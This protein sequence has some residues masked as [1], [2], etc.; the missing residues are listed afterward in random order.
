MRIG[1]LGLGRI[2]AFHAET[3]SGLDAVESLVVSDPFADAA[4]AAAERFGAQVADSPEAVLAAGVD[5]VVVA[6]ATDAHPAL[7]LSCAEAGVPVFCEKPVARTMAEGVRVLKAVE[8]LDVPIQI[9]FNRRFDAGFVSAREAVRGGELGDLHTVRSTTLDPAPPPAAYIAASGGI[10]R[11]CSVHDFDIIRWVTGREVG[12]V[13]AA[14]GN[15]GAA[16]IK[17]AGDADTTG[18]LLTLDDGTLAVVSN[19]RHNARGYDV[20]MELH[21]FRDS[22]A[23]GLEDKLPLRSVEPGVTFP[24]GT[25][26]DFFM[27]RFTAAYRAELTAF[28]EVVAGSRPSPCTVA[29][30]L[31]AG[32]IAEA[33]TL[34]LHEHRPVTLEEVRHA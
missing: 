12:E 20:R 34:S 26:H 3:L 24:A 4:K 28:T 9:G 5:G 16:F 2:G 10:F 25:P 33:C 32:W 8:G 13:Y 18:A 27:D 7:I 17:E 6:A 23:V 22:I 19:S 1:I 21:G 15:R 30:A 31:E 14:G 29:D 11:D